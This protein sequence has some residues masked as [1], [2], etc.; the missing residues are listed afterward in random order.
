MSDTVPP[1]PAA[2]ARGQHNHQFLPETNTHTPKKR[3]GKKEKERN[4]KRE[5]KERKEK[6]RER[7][8][9]KN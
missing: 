6:K 7:K 8:E 2:M 5:R 9:R 3:K 4:G 1:I